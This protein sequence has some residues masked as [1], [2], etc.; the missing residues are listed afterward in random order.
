MLYGTRRYFDADLYT[1]TLWLALLYCC[2]VDVDGYDSMMLSY[3]GPLN[4]FSEHNGCVFAE[5]S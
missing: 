1:S 4:V 5:C 2:K 3:G